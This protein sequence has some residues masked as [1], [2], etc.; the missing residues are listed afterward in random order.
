MTST[1][2]REETRLRLVAVRQALGLKRSEIAD[3]IGLDRSSYTKIESGTKALSA[4]I[5]YSLSE[6]Y[7]VS[8]DYLFRGRLTD[9][10]EALAISLRSQ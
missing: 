8:M 6:R 7:G 10:P 9:L 1:I 4:D 5:A 2:N 3:A